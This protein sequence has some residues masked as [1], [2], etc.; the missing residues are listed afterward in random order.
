M[1]SGLDR[2]CVVIARTRHRMVAVEIHEAAK[3][4]AKMLEVRLDF[5][6][7]APDLRRLLDRKPCPMIA[8]LRWKEDGGRWTG[9]EGARRML[10]RQ[11]IV[12][13]FD[14]VDLEVDV[15]DEIRRFGPA[16]RIVSY[17]NLDCVP[18]NLEEIYEKMCH[19]DADVL[20]LAV[21]A[22]Q[23][24]DNIRILNLLKNAKRPTLAHCIG[25]IG[26]PSRILS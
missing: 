13:G 15:A 24:A 7:R 12:G 20:K 5:I 16:K 8:T 26:F 6:S 22:Q 19:Q 11:C 10:L 2:V 21:A 23:P 4:G 3:L 14:W 9:P 25:D 1:V 18:D 17:H